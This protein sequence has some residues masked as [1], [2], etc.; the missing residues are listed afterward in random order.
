MLNEGI[1]ANENMKKQSREEREVKCLG[2][3]GGVGVER[4]A[5]ILK[6]GG[7]KSTEVKSLAIQSGVPTPGTLAHLDAGSQALP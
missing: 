3:G 7:Q 1:N 6:L 4:R 5:G 2:V